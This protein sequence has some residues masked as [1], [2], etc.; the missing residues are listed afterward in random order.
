MIIIQHYDELYDKSTRPRRDTGDVLKHL[1]ETIIG[2]Y[3]AVLKFSF[4]VKMHLSGGVRDKIGHAIGGFL[5]F[6]QAKFQGQLDSIADLKRKISE[7][8]QAVFQ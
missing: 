4:T 8:S 7:D 5:G 1:F 2:T 3:A 6:A